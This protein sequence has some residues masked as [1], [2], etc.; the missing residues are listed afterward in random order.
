MKKYHRD[1]IISFRSAMAR[2][3]ETGQEFDIIDDCYYG[4]TR[5]VRHREN[6]EPFCGVSFVIIVH[7]GDE[8][9]KAVVS[10]MGLVP[11]VMDSSWVEADPNAILSFN[12]QDEAEKAERN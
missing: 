3:I 10:A 9:E 4:M 7:N 8:D 12:E 5:M 2:C 1:E 6:I 11:D